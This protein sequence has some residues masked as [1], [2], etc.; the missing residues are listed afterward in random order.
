MRARWPVRTLPSAGYRQR[1]LA[2]VVSHLTARA[3]KVS[4]GTR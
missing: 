2:G 3:I 1:V 4:A